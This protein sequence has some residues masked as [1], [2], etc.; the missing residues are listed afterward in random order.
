MLVGI[1]SLIP[2][3]MDRLSSGLI[4]GSSAI[5]Q[6]VTRSEAGIIRCYSDRSEPNDGTFSTMVATHGGQQVLGLRQWEQLFSIFYKS[7]DLWCGLK[8]L[9]DHSASLLSLIH[10]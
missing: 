6:V 7:R 2:G 5:G 10:I 1:W 3:G 4:F 8:T 9:R